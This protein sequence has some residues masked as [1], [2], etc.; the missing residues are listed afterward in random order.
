MD[1][2]TILLHLY[3]VPMPEDYDGRVMEDG[4]MLDFIQQRAIIHQLGDEF[5][6][7]DL[8]DRFTSKVS[9]TLNEH[10]I[11]LRYLD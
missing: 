1:L 2:S 3:T 4:I 8:I 6:F 9:Y 7:Q 5:D 10:L 11:A